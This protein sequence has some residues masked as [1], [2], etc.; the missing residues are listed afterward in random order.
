MLKG[1]FAGE[2]VFYTTP[3]CFGSAHA[4]LYYA[5]AMGL[6]YFGVERINANPQLLQNYHLLPKECAKNGSHT[7]Q[8]QIRLLHIL[9][10]GLA[11]LNDE[12]IKKLAC[13]LQSYAGNH[14]MG[15][16]GI[17][18]PNGSNLGGGDATIASICRF[19]A[20][21]RC[22]DDDYSD[23]EN[24]LIR[25]T[26]L[27]RATLEGRVVDLS[28]QIVKIMSQLSSLPVASTS[29]M[30]ALPAAAAASVQ[31]REKSSDRDLEFHQFL[32]KIKAVIA[33]Y[34]YQYE[35]VSSAPET[36]TNLSYV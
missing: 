22:R 36:V 16:R 17:N 20:S 31:Q 24:E 2:P 8:C 21:A 34:S 18:F 29:A 13:S 19:Y 30:M 1:A 11:Q 7:Y 33:V 6:Y 4:D 28:P 25:E 15:V 32:G 26:C 10:C 35:E 23:W 5:L 9:F 12:S 14:T 3:P 27:E